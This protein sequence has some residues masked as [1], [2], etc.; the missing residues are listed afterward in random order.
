[1][2]Q[3]YQGPLVPLVLWGPQ[4][5]PAPRVSQAHLDRR[6]RRVSQAIRD[7]RDHK[8]SKGHGEK[9]VLL[10]HRGRRDHQDRPVLQGLKA[11][12]ALRG[13]PVLQ[14]Q[15]ASLVLADPS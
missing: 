8:G 10:A 13:E 5:L 14:V 9:P 6:G 12:R 2:K 7:L 11:K 1:M 4:V 15:K 3:P